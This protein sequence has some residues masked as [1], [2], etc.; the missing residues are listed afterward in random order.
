LK[1]QQNGTAAINTL[2]NKIYR[3]WPLLVRSVLLVALVFVLPAGSAHA[4]IQYVKNIG[5]QNSDQ[6]GDTITINVPA[7]GVAAGNSIIVTFAMAEDTGD[8]WCIDTQGNIY[9]GYSGSGSASDVDVSSNNNVRTVIFSAHNVNALGLGDFIIVNHPTIT[10]RAVSAHEFSGL[11]TS[12]TLDQTQSND[13]NATAFSS[14]ATAATTFANE[15]LNFRQYYHKLGI[16]GSFRDQ[17]IY[18]HRNKL[19]QGKICWSHCDLQGSL[20]LRL[21]KVDHH[22]WRQCGR[23][24]RVSG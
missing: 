13:G 3:I 15:L 2:R 17:R 24:Q 19:I 20:H 4:A 16:P 6:S 21:P 10:D 5:T 8:V 9:S 23:F 12:S 14:G 7:A 1:Y 22:R 18:G 11:A